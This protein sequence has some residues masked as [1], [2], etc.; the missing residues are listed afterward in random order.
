MSMIPGRYQ[1]LR[2]NYLTVRLLPLWQSQT[3]HFCRSRAYLRGKA[4]A[5][6]FIGLFSLLFR[7]VGFI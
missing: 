4:D 7:I 5:L 3:S 2:L 6:F 1:L